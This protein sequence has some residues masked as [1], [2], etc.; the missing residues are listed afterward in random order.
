MIE[1]IPLWAGHAPVGDG[2][3]EDSEAWISVYRAANANGASVLICPGGS[4]SGLALDGEGYPVAEWLANHGITAI[5][6]EYRPAPREKACAF[7][8]C[9]ARHPHHSHER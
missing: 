6:L 2:Q 7:A 1:R 5:V 8:G 4:Y 9:A 3:S